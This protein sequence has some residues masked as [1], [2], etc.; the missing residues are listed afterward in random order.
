[1]AEI[2]KVSGVVEVVNERGFK[3][4]GQPGWF[5]I[6]KFSKVEPGTLPGKGTHVVA[7]VADGK[8]LNSVTVLSKA[9]KAPAPSTAAT[10]GSGGG[11]EVDNRSRDIHRQVA[12]KAAVD[13]FRTASPIV[14]EAQE[15][16]LIERVVWTAAKFS[17]YLDSPL[18]PLPVSEQSIDQASIDDDILPF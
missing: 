5:N 3:L 4:E 14:D 16:A 12:L 6:S 18:A 11:G 7:V 13:L 8:F 1:M 2:T 17:A 9:P 15:T 10:G